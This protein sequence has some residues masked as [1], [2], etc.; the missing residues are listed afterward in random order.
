MALINTSTGTIDANQST[1]LILQVGP[2]EN[3]GTV[4]ASSGGTLVLMGVLGEA[5]ANTATGKIE[6]SGTLV[7]NGITINGGTLLN[8]GT[9]SNGVI[10]NQAGTM[11]LLGSTIGSGTTVTNTALGT[12]NIED[13]DTATF[14]NSTITN[15]GNINLNSTGDPTEL[16]IHTFTLTLSGTGTLSN[17][18]VCI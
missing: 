10:T 13:G 4:E 1:P 18:G 12:I 3:S 15:N 8:G 16:I 7:L 2:V 14:S 5:W 9:I 17:T 6:N 11:R